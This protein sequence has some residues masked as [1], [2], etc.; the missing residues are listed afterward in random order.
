MNNCT[1]FNKDSFHHKG[2]PTNIKDII[3]SNKINDLNKY[4]I[5]YIPETKYL[6]NVTLFP[7]S[8]IF[9]YYT[10]YLFTFNE[11]YKDYCFINIGHDIDSYNF[12]F[13]AIG[14][15]INDDMRLMLL[16]FLILFISH[17]C[18]IYI[19]CIKMQQKKLI[20]SVYQFFFRVN[21]SLLLIYI[22]S[23]IPCLFTYLLYCY[24]QSFIFIYLF[25]FVN[26]FKILDNKYLTF[27]DK[28]V[29]IFFIFNS[30]LIIFIEY[31]VYYIPSINN[32]YLLAIQDVLLHIVLLIK[33]IISFK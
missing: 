10:Y 8:T 26:R 13:I 14:K 21:I 27:G 3:D 17:A 25:S 18:L 1:I 33:I 30:L 28:N 5:V 29:I 2:K 23:C 12:Y 31:I 4:E 15:I 20:F 11:S 24:H 9:L 16:T 6:Q 7:K 32:F 19:I 22:C